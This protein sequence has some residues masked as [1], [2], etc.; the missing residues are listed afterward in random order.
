MRGCCVSIIASLG[1]TCQLARH[2]TAASIL[3]YFRS[4]SQVVHRAAP[5]GCWAGQPRCVP[6][7][8]ESHC[9]EL[10]RH[11]PRSCFF[12]RFCWRF[13]LLLISLLCCLYRVASDKRWIFSTSRWSIGAQCRH[14]VL[15]FPVPCRVVSIW[16]FWCSMFN[17]F[18]PQVF[19]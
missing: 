12:V 14:R 15:I 6:F 11:K 10:A 16:A 5:L 1:V 3:R 17:V 9:E 13:L 19:F 7:L 8:V 2:M 18:L 4:M